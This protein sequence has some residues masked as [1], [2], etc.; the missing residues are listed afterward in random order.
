[1]MDL[2]L[3][4][5]DEVVETAEQDL[6]EWAIEPFLA[7][8]D[9][10][11]SPS[12]REPVTLQEYLTPETYRYILCGSDGRLEPFLDYN[13]PEESM[14]DGLNLNEVKLSP[15]LL[16]FCPRQI[17]IQS[18]NLDSGNKRSVLR[19]INI[20]RRMEESF[21]SRDM[22]NMSRLYGVVQDN[23]NGTLIGLLLSWIDCDNTTLE[24]ALTPDTP[25][26]LRGKWEMQVTT[27]LSHLHKAGIIWGDAKA[28]NVL[29]DTNY[30]AWIIDFG[31]RYTQGWV[32]EHRME[33]IDGDQEDL[34]KI[35]ELLWGETLPRKRA[36]EDESE[37]HEARK[38]S[39]RFGL[40]TW[41]L[42]SKGYNQ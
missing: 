5:D 20:Y 41:F 19:E 38:N 12:S 26:D 4:D 21:E 35:K 23:L 13:V 31:G 6:Q 18:T 42:I 15:S 33:T 1:M 30:D 28:A 17:E 39:T 40:T 24:C 25:L 22:M 10:I 7:I 3:D 2:V 34:S 36:M 9:K 11:E 14:S 37:A 8:F 29:I 27:A 32:D 16:S